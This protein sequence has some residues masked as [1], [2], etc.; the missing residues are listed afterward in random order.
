MCDF[1]AAGKSLDNDKV[2]VSGEIKIPNLSDE[3]EVED[4]DVSYRHL[5]LVSYGHSVHSVI[6]SSM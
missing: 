3:N 2:T 4:V 1:R 6:I 5:I